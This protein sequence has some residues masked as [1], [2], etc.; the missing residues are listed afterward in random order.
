MTPGLRAILR[1]TT[2]LMLDRVV[3]MVLG[4][5]LGAWIARH[6]GPRDFGSLAYVIAFMGF[7]QAA[8]ALGLDLV[9]ARDLARAPDL[10]GVLMGAALRLRLAAGAMGLMVACG[11]MWLVR[12]ADVDSLVLTALCSLT[13]I[14]QPADL[15]DLWFQSQGQ[16]RQAVL[17]RVTAFLV[18]SGLRVLFIVY[19]APL[20]FFAMAYSAES[21]L[22]FSLLL[23]AYRRRKTPSAWIYDGAVAKKLMVDAWPLLVSSLAIMVYMRFD[24]ILLRE[25]Q[26]EAVLGLY[27][28]VLPF[29]LA[30]HF[31]PAAI[32]VSVT[33]SLARLHAQD[34]VLFRRRVVSLFSVLA[35]TSMAISVGVAFLAP[36]VTSLLLGP[37]YDG[38]G[39]VLAIHVFSN[40]PVFLGVAQV[41]YLSIVGKTR[42]IMVQTLVGMCVAVGMNL[43]LIPHYGAQGAATSSVLAFLASGVLSNAVLEP[44]L[45]RMQVAAILW[46]GGR[47]G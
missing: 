12:S 38:A 25:M 21:L 16:S 26:G 23:M 9:L 29:S 27:S 46:Q 20:W 19:H 33:P 10:A 1:N 28:A 43:V 44:E 36:T 31:I 2:W 40:V 18:V 42:V 32:C 3:R 11:V 17:P 13:L 8:S 24:Q 22:A 14:L 30:W 7:F 35:W 47:N 4:I 41:R 45:F 34:P 6:L 5:T 37:S 39:S 15:M